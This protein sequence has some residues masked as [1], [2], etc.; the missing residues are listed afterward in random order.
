MDLVA[1]RYFTETARIGNLTK[2]SEA[3]GISASAVFRQIKLLENELGVQLY[4]RTHTGLT[5]TAAGKE[6]NKKAIE[7]LRLSDA[8]VREISN[9]MY[10]ISE[11]LNIAFMDDSFS[12][13]IPGII[14][15]FKLEHPYIKLVF[16]SGIRKNILSMLKKNNV[17]I[18]CM[19]YYQ[20]PR[21]VEYIKSNRT[22]PLGILMRPDDELADR[23]IDYSVLKEIP[24]VTPQTE[25]VNAD[26]MINLPYDPFGSNIVAETD[27]PFNFLE[28]VLQ[29]KGY[30]YCI[31]P[32]EVFLQSS[33]L[34]FR[35]ISPL[36]TA[37]MFF[38]KSTHPVHEE[39][40]NM[41]FEFL[42]TVYGE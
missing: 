8:A 29:K 1:L 31:E 7:I 15:R 27:S 40:A 37:T 4:K 21:E 33:D 32:S 23:T 5:L 16:F 36:I 24:L 34:I 26:R 42:K 3:L 35:P 18:A 10:E 9:R 25:L 6:L 41:F 38:V 39:S 12:R 20:K 22:C 17:D 19:Y 28:L 30:I 14:E 11:P 2:A 13:D